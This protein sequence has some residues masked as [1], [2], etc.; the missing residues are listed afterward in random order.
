ME[1]FHRI[2]EHDIILLIIMQS[3]F[4]IISQTAL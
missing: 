4:V 3:H 1:I 2:T